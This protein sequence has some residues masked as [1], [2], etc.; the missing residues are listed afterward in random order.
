ML[1]THN[2]LASGPQACF[3][4]EKAIAKVKV[5]KGSLGEG[6]HPQEAAKIIYANSLGWANIQERTGWQRLAGRMK[7][8][9]AILSE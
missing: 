9:G 6:G 2:A 1:F 5:G 3:F 4:A 8:P 7:T